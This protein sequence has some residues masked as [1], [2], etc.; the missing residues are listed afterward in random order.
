MNPKSGRSLHPG[1]C[2]WERACQDNGM[3]EES[4]STFPTHMYK[5]CMF[6]Q[7]PWYGGSELHNSQSCIYKTPC[8]TQGYR[9]FQRCST[10][11]LVN[12]SCTCLQEAMLTS[13][14]RRKTSTP[15]KIITYIARDQ[16]SS[17]WQILYAFTMKVSHSPGLGTAGELKKNILHTINLLKMSMIVA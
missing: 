4:P 16:L 11:S 15:T 7:W 5:Q 9:E 10:S 3:H 6:L 17:D 2:Y 12:S 1:K 13:N 8:K 14:R